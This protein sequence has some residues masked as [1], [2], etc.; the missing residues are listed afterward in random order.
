MNSCTV[1][2]SRFMQLSR[3]LHFNL[4]LM[5]FNDFFYILVGM[6]TLI[7]LVQICGMAILPQEQVIVGKMES[8][9]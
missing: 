9:V 6:I 3:S 2:Y 7:F 1:I 5:I 4:R 8:K